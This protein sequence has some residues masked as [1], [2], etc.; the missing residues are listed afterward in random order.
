MS[1]ASVVIEKFGSLSAL[2]RAL[3]HKHPTTVQGWVERQRIPYWHW[4]AIEVAAARVGRPDLSYEAILALHAE[5][6][7]HG[8]LVCE[9][10]Q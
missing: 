4:K 9:P 10:A 8:D 5:H 3:G 7:E 1:P 2:S 6:A